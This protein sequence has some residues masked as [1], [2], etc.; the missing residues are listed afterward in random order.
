MAKRTVLDF[1]IDADIWPTVADW[2]KRRGFRIVEQGQVKSGE[3]SLGKWQRFNK[4]SVLITLLLFLSNVYVEIRQEGKN[5]QIQAW[6]GF[7]GKDQDL[8]RGFVGGLPR[9]FARRDVND[10]LRALGQ[11][12]I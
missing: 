2:A 10:L 7:Y 1:Q 5:V 12:T 8:R 3:T 9:I 6:I 4:S 11:R